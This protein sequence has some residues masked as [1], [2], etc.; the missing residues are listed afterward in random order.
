[1]SNEPDR[2]RLQ[3]LEARLKEA[4]GE[5]KQK[6]TG[7]EAYNQASFAW[8]MVIELTVGLL[9]GFGIGYG[10]DGLFGTKPIFMVLFMML[11]FAAGMKVMLS[12]AAQMQK[13]AEDAQNAQNAAEEEGNGRG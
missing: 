8:Q 9:I 3:Q 12:T 4:K 13:K 11:G 5:E 6:K 1:M 7:D 10:L 2:E